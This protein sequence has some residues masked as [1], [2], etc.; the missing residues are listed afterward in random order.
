LSDISVSVSATLGPA[1]SATLSAWTPAQR[2]FPLRIALSSSVPWSVEWKD[3]IRETV[4]KAI[5]APGQSDALMFEAAPIETTSAEIGIG[6]ARR[7]I[8]VRDGQPMSRI[9]LSASVAHHLVSENETDA[10]WALNVIANQLALVS[11]MELVERTLPGVTLN[12]PGNAFQLRL[13]ADIDSAIVGYVAC[14]V[15]G[16]F[17]DPE[18][19]SRTYRTLLIGAL[20]RLKTGVEKE[21]LAYRTSGDLDRLIAVASNAISAVLTF[22]AQLLGNADANDRSPL[23]EAGLLAAGLQRLNLTAWLSDYQRHL[24]RFRGQLGRW[25][26]F[27][28]FLSFNRHVERLLWSVGM[29]PWA[30]SEGVRFEI[31]LFTDAVALMSQG[32]N[33]DR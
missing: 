4:E 12:P 27:D 13:Y 9:V 3:K 29:F 10:D 8:V 14:Y 26:S 1:D 17:G 23:D 2:R 28:E 30:T 5:G 15:S 21:R 7:I 25:R 11:M 24:A 32:T 31:P 22:A 33:A 6:I 19:I 20:D 16:G 18:E